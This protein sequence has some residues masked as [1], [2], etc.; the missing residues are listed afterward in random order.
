MKRSILE[1]PDPF[2]LSPMLALLPPG[3]EM[4]KLE[5]LTSFFYA[6]Y[7]KELAIKRA[8]DRSNEENEGRRVVTAELAMLR[9]VLECLGV[10]PDIGEIN[11]GGEDGA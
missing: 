11:G 2:S 10:N 7:E 4:R 9:A 8:T 3:G 6:R 5:S 1:P